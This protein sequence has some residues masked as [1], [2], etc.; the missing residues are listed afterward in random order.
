MDQSVRSKPKQH[1]CYRQQEQ[2]RRQSHTTPHH[3]LPRRWPVPPE[4]P[5]RPGDRPTKTG[6]RSG[7]SPRT[8]CPGGRAPPGSPLL[9]TVVETHTY[10]RNTEGGGAGRGGRGFRRGG[11]GGVIIDR[12]RSRHAVLVTKHRRP[13]ISRRLKTREGRSK[14]AGFAPD[15]DYVLVHTQFSTKREGSTMRC[16]LFRRVTRAIKGGRHPVRF[17]LSERER[18]RAKTHTAHHHLCAYTNLLYR[19]LKIYQHGSLVYDALTPPKH[20]HDTI[21]FPPCRYRA[22]PCRTNSDTRSVS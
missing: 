4:W 8:S 12:A 22:L 14:P 17:V 10:H 5:R 20:I 21:S 19:S 13:P 6:A 3:T 11:G 9:S 1:Y 2:R 15:Q 7:R 16:L 18:H